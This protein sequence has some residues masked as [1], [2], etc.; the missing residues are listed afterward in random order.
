MIE[1]VKTARQMY[2]EV[3]AAPSRRRFGFGRRAALVNIDLQCA[4]T[5]VGTYVTAYET[6]PRQIEYVNALAAAFRSAESLSFP[7][8]RKSGWLLI[9]PSFTCLSAMSLS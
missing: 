8:V 9:Q 3:Q 1:E 4:Y 7:V 5:Q 6:D 2:T